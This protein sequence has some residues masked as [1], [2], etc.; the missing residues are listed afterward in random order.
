MI[1]HNPAAVRGRGGLP[2]R[3][4]R[5]LAGRSHACVVHSAWLQS[6][7]DSKSRNVWVAPHPPYAET[8]KGYARKATATRAV[9]SSPVVAFVGAMRADKGS[10]DLI[11][12]AKA[13][14]GNWTLRVLGPDRLPQA[15]EERLSEYG[16]TC[17]YPSAG[18]VPTDEELIRGLLG[19]DLMIAPYRSVT[20]SGSV[21]MAFGLNV[22]VLAYY[23]EGLVRIV[24]EKSLALSPE[25][26]GRLISAYFADPWNTFTSDARH[27]EGECAEKWGALLDAGF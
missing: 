18:K 21:H 9:Q 22:A 14:E 4:E 3:L 24:N 15:M 12:I 26:L 11:D 8:T 10:M 5:L 16:V 13:V 27:L 6:K 7:L 20:E 1:Y 19:S 2:G 23:S 25:A 17:E